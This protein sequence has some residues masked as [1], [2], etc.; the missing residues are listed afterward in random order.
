MLG[1]GLKIPIQETGVKLAPDRLEVIQELKHA[2][3]DLT[4]N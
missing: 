1:L 4:I 2:G 3:R